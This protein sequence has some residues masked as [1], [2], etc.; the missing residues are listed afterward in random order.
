M[1]A[2]AAFL[3][4]CSSLG[5]VAAKDVPVYD[6]YVTQQSAPGAIF[7]L[8]DGSGESLS[9][10]GLTVSVTIYDADS[11][12]FPAFPVQ[13]IVLVD[14]QGGVDVSLCTAA[15]RASQMTNASGETT[16]EGAAFGG[17]S[18]DRGLIAYL[19]G[20]N[21]GNPVPPLDIRVVSADL[22]GDLVVG[23]LD[24]ANVPNGFAARYRTGVYDWVIDLNHDDAV[25]LLDI[26]RFA[27]AMGAGCP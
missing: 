18:T 10:L 2:S 17:G 16:I 27:M 23:I 6:Y 8:P 21:F 1:T 25:N 7:V 15:W 5:L 20:V 12:P 24:L 13:D 22:D 11:D 4:I 26:S 9:E 19:I 14:S 3:L